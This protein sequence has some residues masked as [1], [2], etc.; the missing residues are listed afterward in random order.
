[1][2]FEVSIRRRFVLITS[3][4]YHEIFPFFTVSGYSL[5]PVFT[6]WIATDVCHYYPIVL[7][8]LNTKRNSKLL[9]AESLLDSP[10]SDRVGGSLQAPVHCHGA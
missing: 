1:M 5:Q 8:C 7:C 9:L 2:S 3:V 6:R 10:D 4:A